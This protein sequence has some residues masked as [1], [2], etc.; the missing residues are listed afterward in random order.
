MR[1]PRSTYDIGTHLGEAT[2]ESGLGTGLGQPGVADGTG[3]GR[4]KRIRCRLGWHMWR[5][6]IGPEGDRYTACALCDKVDDA[7]GSIIMPGK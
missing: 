1:E 3:E 7:V 2:P 4:G 5:P 6:R